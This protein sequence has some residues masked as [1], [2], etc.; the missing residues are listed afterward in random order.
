MNKLQLI[1]LKMNIVTI[2]S[3]GYFN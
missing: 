1:W 3:N 2:W